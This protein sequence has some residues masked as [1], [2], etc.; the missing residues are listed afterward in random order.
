MPCQSNDW[1]EE[2]A[3]C[4]IYLWRII[5][6]WDQEGPPHF[7]PR[8]E[9]DYKGPSRIDFPTVTASDL[10]L[11]GKQLYRQY[12]IRGDLTFQELLDNVGYCWQ[13]GVID[14][15]DGIDGNGE[16]EGEEV[17]VKEDE[18]TFDTND[19]MMF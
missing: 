3:F 2:I 13:M 12:G 11:V 1:L 17:E 14:N 10:K 5:A 6:H 8:P 16:G 4:N 19:K 7:L 9:S 18:K 15:L